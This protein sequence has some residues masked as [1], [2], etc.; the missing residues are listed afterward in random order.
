MA[1]NKLD[2]KKLTIDFKQLMRLSVQDRINFYR[3]G[4]ASYFESL[5]PTQLAQLFPKYYQ[6][7][8]PDIGKAVSGGTKT[9]GSGGGGGSA[10]ATPYYGGGGGV[11]SGG[12]TGGAGGPNASVGAGKSAPTGTLPKPTPST[13]AKENS[14]QDYIK[15]LASTSSSGDNKIKIHPTS[16]PL[17]QVRAKLFQQMNDPNI[18]AAVF[19]RVDIEVGG[20]GPK[21]QQA[22]MEAIANR[23]AAR[24]M[25]LYDV[26]S[27]KDGYY[28]RKDD[29]KWK[30]AASKADPNLEK[31][32]SDMANTVGSGSNIAKFATGNASGTV[33]V[34]QQ[35]FESNG[36]R[37]GIENPDA[38]WAKSIIKQMSEYEKSSASN[39][40]TAGSTPGRP[41][42]IGD[43][44]A[45]MYDG[46]N[47]RGTASDATQVS[48][49][50][51]QILA[52]I[53]NNPVSP[54]T[55]VRLS[56][57]ILN[58]NGQRLNVIEQMAEELKKQGANVEIIGTPNTGKHNYNK[59]LEDL[60]NKNGF[61]FLG[62]YTPGPDG[63]HPQNTT[64][65]GQGQQQTNVPSS[66]TRIFFDEERP[67]TKAEHAALKQKYG[68]NISVGGF[69]HKYLET[70][71]GPTNTSWAPD[72][73]AR[74][75][76]RAAAMGMS[77]D[78]YRRTGFWKDVQK[79]V[80]M[81][82]NNSGKTHELDNLGINGV[83]ALDET[84][85]HLNW[86][87][88]N[89][90]KSKLL[91]K[92]LDD[93]QILELARR[94][95]EYKN[96]V[97]GG[98]TE[99]D[100]GSYKSQS[101]RVNKISAAYK[102]IG[103]TSMF[104]PDVNASY[105]YRSPGERMIGDLLTI[106]GGSSATQ[107]Q[108]TI[109]TGPPPPLPKSITD[110]EEYKK[111]LETIPHGDRDDFNTTLSR[112][113]ADGKIKETDAIERMR[114]QLNQQPAVQPKQSTGAPGATPAPV[115]QQ[116]Q[117]SQGTH[118][119][120]QESQLTPDKIRN[121][122]INSGLKQ[123]LNYA[124]QK[125]GV[126]VEVVSGGQPGIG[127]STRRTGSTRHDHGNAADIKLYTIDEKG[128]KRYLDMT[129][130]K[131][132]QIM[133]QFVS[134]SVHAGA[135]GVGAGISY[136]GPN[137]MHIGGGNPASW[138]GADWI[139]RSRQNGINLRKTSGPVVFEQPAPKA[140]PA[141]V[142]AAAPTAVPA[143][144]PTAVPAAAPAQPGSQKAQPARGQHTLGPPP[145][146]TAPAAAPAAVPAAAPTAVPAPASTA[147]A[148]PA[149]T[150][151]APA[152]QAP[153][154]TAPAQTAPA[155]TAPAPAQQAPEPKSNAQGGEYPAEENMGVID[156]A[157]NLK[158]TFNDKED[159]SVKDGRIKI[160]PE[161]RTNP[162]D[163]KPTN[164]MPKKQ[165]EAQPKQ[166][167][168]KS[169]SMNM[170]INTPTVES[171]FGNRLDSP[172]SSLNPAYA[173]A[174]K[175]STSFR[176]DPGHMALRSPGGTLHG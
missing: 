49:Q 93:K 147:P 70:R 41:L 13:T 138:G 149:Q 126:Q 57:G 101:E 97:V 134:H 108:P 23:A 154:P 129:N 9:F 68:E 20:Q 63:V 137:T 144:A 116:A 90:I 117:S 15:K 21:A 78:E 52:Y 128:N 95:P 76:A 32:Y 131:E 71:G 64:I 25:S 110:S 176:Q 165:V 12:T 118:S 100:T 122:P 114:N 60:A 91:L 77:F 135:T 124:A 36:E 119:L 2:P 109:S 62:G 175:Q 172:L 159:F 43:S 74:I 40:P 1:N 14:F 103:L 104:A 61:R 45:R 105:H 30:N 17:A 111:F 162:D 27:N 132:R 155:Q 161:N 11:Y 42:Y 143:A 153:E 121:L 65:P 158:Y 7:A 166:E 148:A 75:N 140:V 53:K 120:I 133:E 99:A 130:P 55:T 88:D 102:Q 82:S 3:Q 33:G 73:R 59:F 39:I 51:E 50:P 96:H 87:K 4:G 106:Q 113:I 18:R 31:K 164:Q 86:M 35:T 167:P 56:T 16:S 160:T 84:I 22:F 83:S 92:N 141:A 26:V 44:V 67:Y 79:D 28:P 85:Q 123:Q 58:S 169:A 80:T 163:L 46:K 145:A 10:T 112:V 48:R 89:N 81:H 19:A 171:N 152:Q 66:S 6:Q 37:F 173:R 174:L 47:D 125:T 94:F 72:E 34:G 38:G 107:V 168:R 156:R 157:G 8:L 69:E 115:S 151:P 139:E 54:G 136:M 127:T 170:P 24:R 146:Q 142:P 29:Y 150:A 98:F 5:T